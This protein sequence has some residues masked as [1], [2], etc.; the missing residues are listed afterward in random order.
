MSHPNKLDNVI[1]RG[2]NVIAIFVNFILML[3]IIYCPRRKFGDALKLKKH[4]FYNSQGHQ[5]AGEYL[6]ILFYSFILM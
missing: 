2:T 3:K 4:T 1:A 6:S 5:L